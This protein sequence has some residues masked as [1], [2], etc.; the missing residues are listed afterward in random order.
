MTP[1]FVILVAVA[2]VCILALLVYGKDGV[3]MDVKLLSDIRHDDFNG[4]LE[5][6]RKRN[7]E[8]VKN[9]SVQL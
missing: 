3:S 2:W 1:L 8:F 5:S 6:A 7:D 9:L 4:R